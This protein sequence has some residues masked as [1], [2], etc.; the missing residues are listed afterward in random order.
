MNTD[1]NHE[2]RG[3]WRQGG[4]EWLGVAEGGISVDEALTVAGLWVEG[5]AGQAVYAVRWW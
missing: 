3:G 1:D 4:G 5:G 2:E